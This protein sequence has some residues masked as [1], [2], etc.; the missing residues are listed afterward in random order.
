MSRP[1]DT[2]RP[3]GAQRLSLALRRV[4]FTLLT[5]MLLVAAGLLSGTLGGSIHP[6]LVVR[7]GF[8]PRD[9][10]ALEWFRVVASVFLTAGG[11]AFW[12]AALSVAVAVGVSEWRWGTRRAATVFWGAHI[13]TLLTT[14]VI[15]GALHVS[16]LTLGSLLYEARDIGPSAGYV[17]AFGMALTALPRALRPWVALAVAALLAFALGSSLAILPLQ[18]ARVSADVAHLIAFGIGTLA[19]TVYARGEEAIAAG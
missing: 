11:L 18:A 19:G 1:I 3:V 12:V 14:L 17:A 6:T 9:L 15:A 8:A 4:P 5:L 7:F 16:G 13:V 2:P 10:I